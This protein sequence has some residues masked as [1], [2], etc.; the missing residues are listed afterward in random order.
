MPVRRIAVRAGTTPIVF[1]MPHT[2]ALR[3]I[4]SSQ[5]RIF[6]KSV[7]KFILKCNK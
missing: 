7:A 1:N 2:L 5:T 3:L 4:A 6:A